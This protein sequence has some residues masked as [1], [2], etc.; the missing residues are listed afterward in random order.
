V[1]VGYGQQKKVHSTGAVAQVDMKAVEDLAV[2]SLGAAIVAQMP[3]VSISGGYNRPGEKPVITVRNPSSYSKDNVSPDG[4]TNGTNPLYVIDGIV[5]TSDDFNNLD[6]SEVESVSVLKDAAAAV[7]G[8]RGA[9]GV[10]IATTKRGKSGAPRFSYN[11]SY[12][13]TDAYSQPKMM[14]GYQLA[15]YANDYNYQ[16]TTPTTTLY[17]D[18]EL[19]YFKTNS[20]SWLDMA[21]KS[22]TQVR[23]ALNISGGTD[24]ATYFAGVTYN[25]QD[26]NF[27]KINYDKWTFRA[28]SDIKV[29]NRIKLGFGI[30]GDISNNKKY[31][32]KQGGSNAEKDYQSLIE[33]SPFKPAYVDGLPVN[34]VGT[35]ASAQNFHFFEALNANNYVQSKANGL[36][37]NASIE[38]DVPVITGLKARLNYNRNYENSFGK[39]FGTSYTLYNFNMLGTNKH[40]YGGGVKNSIKVSNGNYLFYTPLY[41]D[42]YTL[43]GGLNYDKSFGKHKISALALFEQNEFYQDGIRANFSGLMDGADDNIAFSIATSSVPATYGQTVEV[44]AE[45]GRLG[46]IG[47]INYVYADKY[48]L[49]LSVRRDA[50]TNFVGANKWGT[51]PSVSVGWVVSQEPFFKRSLSKIDLLKIRASLGFLGMDNTKAYQWQKSY[52]LIKSDQGVVFGGNS[53]VNTAT[54]FKVAMPNVNVKWDSDTKANFGIDMAT[55]KNRLSLNVDAFY[56]RR[57]DM[58]STLTSSVPLTIG[59]ALPTENFGEVESFGYEISLGWKNQITKDWSYSVKTGFGWNDNRVVKYDIAKA[60]IGT[61]EDQTGQSSD[62]GYWGYKTTGMLRTQADVDA[63]LAKY[64]TYTIEGIKPT[65]GS[66]YYEDVR[67]VATYNADGSFKEY[68]APDGKITTEDRIKLADKSSNHYGFNL[69]FATKY[70]RLSF[71]FNVGG[72]FGGVAEIESAARAWGTSASVTAQT[73]LPAFLADHWTVDNPNATYPAPN[74]RSASSLTS[75]YW[76]RSGFTASVRS[77]NISYEL[78]EVVLRKLGVSS[79]RVY[80]TSNYPLNLYDPFE[81]KNFSGTYNNYP[82]LRSFSGGVSLGF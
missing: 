48:L 37:F 4:T 79:A 1:V 49:E 16:T 39:E 56:D 44:E 13:V 7:Y 61:V 25:K 76:M 53:G 22:A 9:N 35:N 71:S 51:F 74:S 15:K 23:Q 3:G 81:Y 50:S 58:L 24:R 52:E 82:T 17:S 20:Q 45:S 63:L 30:N 80:M 6:V 47:R 78:P 65:V 40:I 26:G 28:S 2:T 46:Y 66:L 38:Y 10:V 54:F 11:S 33:A 75:D 34:L 60:K 31:A 43:N 73:N 70:K 41:S 77:A 68:G 64:P 32:L 69:N 67:G 29:G 42:S 5:R 18:D 14:S 19:E 59:A 8:S 36:N 72:S 55:F 62:L 27:D 57:Y 12:G 21:W